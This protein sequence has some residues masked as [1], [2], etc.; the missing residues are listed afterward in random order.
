LVTNSASDTSSGLPRN[1]EQI[2]N[3][4][5]ISR[6][7]SRLT[8]DA[9]FNLHEFAIDSNFVQHITTFPDL[10]IVLYNP[11]IIDIFKSTLSGN[12]RTQQLSYDT[13][14]NLGDFYVSVLLFR[15]TSLVS[16]PVIPLAFLLHERKLRNTHEE[17]FRQIRA[18]CPEINTASNLIIVTDQE[19]AITKAIRTCFPDVPMFL[20]WNH[21]LQVNK[22]SFS[23]KFYIHWI[24][25]SNKNKCNLHNS[26]S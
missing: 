8:R 21:V 16:S 4:Q 22:L 20:C 18:I 2:R 23:I 13:T 1:T 19:L 3:V 11:S 24:I 6:N 9:L 12:L 15:E 26:I 17:F 10:S 5:K 14:F 25:S 7:S